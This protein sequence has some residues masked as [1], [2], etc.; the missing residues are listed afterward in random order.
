M[1]KTDTNSLPERNKNQESN[2]EQIYLYLSIQVVAGVNYKF[3]LILS[4]QVKL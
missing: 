1:L 2:W 4:E 3:D